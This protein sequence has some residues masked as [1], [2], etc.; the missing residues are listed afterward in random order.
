[1]TERPSSG[2]HSQDAKAALTWWAVLGL[3]Q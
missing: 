2:S 1:V 3:N